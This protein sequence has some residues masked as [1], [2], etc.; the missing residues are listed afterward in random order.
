MSVA[1]AQCIA[2][3]LIAA[4]VCRLY[5]LTLPFKLVPSCL[6]SGL[7]TTCMCVS[8][9]TKTFPL[10]ALEEVE[11][12]QMVNQES[13]ICLRGKDGRQGLQGAQSGIA[14]CCLPW[15]H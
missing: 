6:Q 11:L 5:R 9:G 15:S 12:S 8:F 10:C 2:A 1:P 4:E 7:A 3:V 13:C 14:A